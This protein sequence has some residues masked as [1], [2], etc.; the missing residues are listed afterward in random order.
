MEAVGAVPLSRGSARGLSP[1]EAAE[2]AA[3]SDAVR[4]VALDLLP[5]LDP[6]EA[7]TVLDE[8]L[9]GDPGDYVSSYRILEDRGE[10]PALFVEDPTVAT[11]YVLVVKVSVDVERVR[12]RLTAGGLLALSTAESHGFPLRLVIE[13]LDGF[14][15]YT[16]LRRTLVEGV[17]V[18]SALPVEMER[19]RA[20]L[21]LEADL[22]A[23][24]LLRAL[25]VVAPPELEIVPLAAKGDLLT[26]RVRELD[27]PAAPAGE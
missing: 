5:E 27:L 15:A 18:R 25:L 19:G 1:L 9:G 12:E 4:R 17:G 16:L 22:E 6:A 3:L 14:R 2:R 26:L 23:R 11:E 24:E 20:V 21:E 8:V 7:E 13:E 10:R